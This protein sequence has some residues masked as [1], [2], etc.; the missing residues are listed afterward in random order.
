MKNAILPFCFLLA[1]VSNSCKNNTK[2]DIQN[3]SKVTVLYEGDERIFF[4]DYWGMEASFMMF[5][6]LAK[7]AGSWSGDKLIGMLAK[8]WEHS[9]DYREWTIHLRKNI[10][11]HDGVAVTAHDIK[12]TIDLRNQS[13]SNLFRSVSV[14]VV[15]DYKLVFSSKNPFNGLDIYNVYYPKHLLKDL[16]PEDF[17][18]WDF[19]TEPIG[20]GPYRYVRHVPQTMI[21][22]ESNPDYFLEEPKIKHVVLKFAKDMSLI[23]LISGNVDIL[24]SASRDFLIKLDGDERFESYYWTG[25]WVHSIYWNHN[26]PL[27]ENKRIRKAL[28]MA[29]NRKELIQVLNYPEGLPIID[30]LVTKRQLKN[31]LYPEPIPYDPEKAIQILEEEGWLLTEGEDVRER[32]GN[33]FQFT[34]L[35]NDSNSLILYVQDQFRRIGIQMEIQTLDDSVI[36]QRLYSGEYD[37]ALCWNAFLTPVNIPTF[38]HYKVYGHTS[39]FGYNNP[40]MDSLLQIADTTI[41]PEKLDSLYTQI[42]TI[43]NEDIPMTF[44]F[45]Q[46][47]TYIVKRKIKGLKS[48]MADPTYNMEHL[49]IDESN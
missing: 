8:N 1:L 19:W 27:F 25:S 14:Q 39:T 38:D 42:G 30:A 2:S 20:N 23:E 43:F 29:I 7:R 21:E 17:F 24:P 34:I 16:D 36:L 26:N 10:R 44:L 32:N 46:V 28:T 41:D 37:D 6:P 40:Q 22:V 47:Q 45:Q 15:D 35:F 4:Q 33:K 48:P 18:N 11:W 9:E 5:L 12:F 13:Y 49:W 3:L 31:N